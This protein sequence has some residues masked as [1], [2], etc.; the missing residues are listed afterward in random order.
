MVML[1]VEVKDVERVES[2]DHHDIFYR[3]PDGS[4][5]IRIYIYIYWPKPMGANGR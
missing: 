2:D 4:T 1:I 3:V 5:Y